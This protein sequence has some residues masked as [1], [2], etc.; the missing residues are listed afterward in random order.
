MLEIG[1]MLFTSGCGEFETNPSVD[2][3]IRDLITETA[4]VFHNR[5]GREWDYSWSGE[6][7]VI[8]GLTFR[9]FRYPR[10]DAE[11]EIPPGKETEAEADRQEAALPCMEIEDV[12]IWWYK[13]PGRSM[14][15]NSTL[16]PEQWFDWH[17]RSLRVVV[18]ADKHADDTE[19]N[20]H[21]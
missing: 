6:D 21:T 20:A 2:A 9:G 17:Q 19:Q 7:P 10:Y 11:D 4:R 18:A 16:T 12:S 1:Q 14:T 8:P 3:L 5:T 13:Y 15:V